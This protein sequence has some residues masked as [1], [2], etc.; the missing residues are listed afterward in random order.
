VRVEMSVSCKSGKKQ[1]YCRWTLMGRG[2]RGNGGRI[3]QNR[4][5]GGSGS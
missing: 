2:G 1:S 4:Y 5:L 3:Y